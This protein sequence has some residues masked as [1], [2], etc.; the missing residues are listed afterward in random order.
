VFAGAGLVL[1]FWRLSW[2]QR[3]RSARSE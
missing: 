2:E 1:K 3:L